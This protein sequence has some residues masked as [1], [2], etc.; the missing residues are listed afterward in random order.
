MGK[1]IDETGNTYNL[2]KVKEF[3]CFKNGNA[4]WKC[5]CLSCGKIK[6]VSGFSLRMGNSSGCRNCVQKLNKGES[7]FNNLYIGYLRGA[8]NRNLSF[9][10]EKKY[11]KE[12]TQQNCYYCGIEPH[13]IIN[14]KNRNGI[15]VYNGIDRKDN[16]VGYTVENCVP[17]CKICNFA[18]KQM[19]EQE[20]Y[21]WI[22]RV[23]HHIHRNDNIATN[24]EELNIQV[25]LPV[26]EELEFLP[27]MELL[28][29]I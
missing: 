25:S 8:K 7:N 6:D 12:I 28:E 9:E 27:T 14:N 13:Q 2:W 26:Y 21:S 11:F 24:P 29:V 16:A 1:F 20:F 17:C 18:K 23:Y 19:G 15:Y 4:V 22:D 5:E 10:I 3:S